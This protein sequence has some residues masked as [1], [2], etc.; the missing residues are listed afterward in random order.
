MVKVYPNLNHLFQNCETGDM[1]EY[2]TIEETMAVE[3][4]NDITEWILN[5]NK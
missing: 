1:G 2:A 4:L 3:V 5:I